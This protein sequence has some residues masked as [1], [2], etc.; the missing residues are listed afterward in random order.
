MGTPEQKLKKERQRKFQFVLPLI[1]V[2]F[3]TLFFWGLGGGSAVEAK[4]AGNEEKGLNKVLPDAHLK[5]DQDIDKLSYYDKAASDSAKKAELLKKD[6]YAVQPSEQIST[7]GNAYFQQPPFNGGIPTAP[8]GSPYNGQGYNDPNEAKV[9]QRLQQLNQ[10]LNQPSVPNFQQQ[11]KNYEISKSAGDLERLEQMMERMQAGG[12]EQDPETVQLNGML[13][14]ILDI[15]HPE[16]VQEKLRKTSEENKGLV[17]AVSSA[18]KR[19]LISLLELPKQSQQEKSDHQ[20]GFFSA[21]DYAPEAV[22]ENAI[23]AVVHETQT[24]VN[25]STVKLRLLDDIYIAGKLIPKDNFIFGTATVSGER[26]IIKIPGI[27]YKKSVF[28]VTLSVMDIDGLEGIY[29]PGAI[30]REV[31]KESA[32][33]AIQDVSF[34]TMSDNIGIQA[35]STGVEAAKSLFSKKVKLIKVTIKAGYKILLRD[36]KQK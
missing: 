30:A 35:A 9:Y 5:D 8:L 2:P 1:V 22:D 3:L 10:S 4:Q 15:Q 25:G 19:E 7:A 18:K 17:Y 28:P 26:L 20:N 27:R 23:A 16:R 12:Q 31:A 21:D 13:E 14:R 34:G 24:I 11:N 6:P 32:D 36:E 33:R 29:V